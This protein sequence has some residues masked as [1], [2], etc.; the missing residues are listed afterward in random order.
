MGKENSIRVFCFLFFSFLS[1]PYHSLSFAEKDLVGLSL[2]TTDKNGKFVERLTRDDFEVYEDGKRQNIIDF[3]FAETIN[4][5]L[6]VQFP[7]GEVLWKPRALMIIF[8][9]SAT[10]PFSLQIIKEPLKKF[11][12]QYFCREDN[13]YFFADRAA[14]AWQG[15]KLIQLG[16]KFLPVKD[17]ELKDNFITE[18]ISNLTQEAMDA[19]LSPEKFTSLPETADKGWNPRNKPEEY[20][21]S[22]ELDYKNFTTLNFLERLKAIAKFGE[23][24]EG[25]KIA[26][27]VSEIPRQSP[28]SLLKTETRTISSYITGGKFRGQVV[29]EGKTFMSSFAYPPTLGEWL[30]HSRTVLYSALLTPQ[31]LDVPQLE[32]TDVLKNTLW[33]KEEPLSRT[34]PEL[35]L[36]SGSGSYETLIKNLSKETGGLALMSIKKFDESLSQI[37]ETMRKS[38][39]LSY[40]PSNEKKDGKF[41]KIEVKA[42]RSDLKI[43]HRKGYYALDREKEELKEMERFLEKKMSSEKFKAFLKFT[44]IP[45]SNGRPYLL[46]K[47]EPRG[48]SVNDITWIEDEIVKSRLIA[49]M[50]ILLESKDESTNRRESW[51]KKFDFDIRENQ[52]FL[53]PAIYFGQELEGKKLRVRICLKDRISGE[54]TAQEEVIHPEELKDVA[55]EKEVA[56]NHFLFLKRDNLIK[57]L[58]EIK[59]LFTY[60]GEKLYPRLDEEFKPEENLDFYFEVSGEDKKGIDFYL[61]IITA[62]N[63]LFKTYQMSAPLK[64]KSNPFL[65]SI[66]L[67]DY[68]PGQYI[69]QITAVPRENR[70][71]S[72]SRKNFKVIL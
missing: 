5:R 69:L 48:L 55:Q 52:L 67:R 41:R 37:G 45:L 2:I 72:I 28:E 23:R 12:K 25:E 43:R 1:L 63:Q 18:I 44:A 68:P 54:I 38:Y 10:D 14:F 6:L 19:T 53:R 50:R 34:S 64:E 20:L 26:L 11:L 15:Q 40:S 71:Y 8:D 24:I 27:L 42:K 31:K 56:L 35:N 13:I 57:E 16:R 58:N 4:G 61:N 30:S 70:K 47:I 62:E 3:S 9:Q 36:G 22:F 65:I 32:S 66:P 51:D 17:E 49:Q 59:G 29:D 39:I 46:I 60:Q 21:T 7:D 33:E